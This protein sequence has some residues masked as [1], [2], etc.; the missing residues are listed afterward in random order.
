MFRLIKAEG[1]D[2]VDKLSNILAIHSVEGWFWTMPLAG[3]S[4]YFEYND[5]SGKM[6]RTSLVQ[7]V[8][9]VNGQ[10]RVTTMNS[11]YWFEEVK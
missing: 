11:V 6:M 3:R 7:E 8:V 10:I 4:L 9:Q 1:K 2:G 5:N